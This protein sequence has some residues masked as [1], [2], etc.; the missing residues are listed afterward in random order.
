MGIQFVGG[1]IGFD[2]KTLLGEVQNRAAEFVQHLLPVVGKGFYKNFKAG[3]NPDKRST[4]FSGIFGHKNR[5]LALIAPP[6]QL[7]FGD[8]YDPT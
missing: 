3:I 2:E 7:R 5:I 1:F 8:G 6:R 4:L